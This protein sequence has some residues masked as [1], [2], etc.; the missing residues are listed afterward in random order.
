VLANP[1]RFG[2]VLLLG[3]GGLVGKVK[4]LIAGTIADA[5]VIVSGGLYYVGNHIAGALNVLVE[6]VKRN[7]KWYGGL[8]GVSI[9]RYEFLPLGEKGVWFYQ[10]GA[11]FLVTWS[12]VEAIKIIG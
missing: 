9:D 12:N 1:S 3:Q 4:M 7:P 2:I 5:E 11:E 6:D 10:E 8:E